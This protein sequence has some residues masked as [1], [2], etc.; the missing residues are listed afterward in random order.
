MRPLLLACGLFAT[1][2]LSHT[3][4]FLPPQISGQTEIPD[5]GSG[6][7]LLDQQKEKLI[8][9]KVYREVRRQMPTVQDA[10]LE[11]Q[12]FKCFQVFSAKL[13]LGNRLV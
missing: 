10:W 8:G 3:Q 12:F 6:V 5:I 1:T 7:G 2:Q 13:S 9:E 11:D 4:V